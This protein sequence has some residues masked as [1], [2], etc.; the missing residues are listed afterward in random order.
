MFI[1]V[2]CQGLYRDISEKNLQRHGISTVEGEGCRERVRSV[3]W[4][5]RLVA[6]QDEDHRVD[7]TSFDLFLHLA[8]S[9]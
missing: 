9:F 7:L 1:H 5:T 3:A 8:A 2:H 6:V 4:Q